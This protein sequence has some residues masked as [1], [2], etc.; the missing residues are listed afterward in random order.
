M[1]ELVWAA[2]ASHA[3]GQLRVQTAAGQDQERID[4]VYAGWAQLR[5]S[6]EA[7]GPDV[8]IVVGT[9]HFQTFSYDLMPVFAIGR[10][11]A[12]WTWGEFGTGVTQVPGLPRLA[13]AIHADLVHDGFDLASSAEMRIDHAYSCPLAF[14]APEDS[15]PTVPLFVNS[16]VPP[17]PPLA[18]CRALG[19][20]LRAAIER[21]QIA[22]RVAIVG[23]GGIS[24]WIGVPQTGR[25]NPQF[26]RRFLSDFEA[27]DLSALDALD[28]QTLVRDG[29][30]GAG[31]L[32]CW[33]VTLGA[34]GSLG[35]RTL[36]YEPVQAWI[37]GISLV[38]VAL[39]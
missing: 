24:H 3:G 33:M 8:L 14:L 19:V 32:R 17:L 27:P 34:A 28:D 38:E 5:Q 21:Q 9:D 1:G 25:I 18:R 15:I 35:A 12:S 29:G 7:A 22:R 37:T 2:C 4:R 31:E 20:A 39:S 16:F 10:G 6:L 26:D 23:T 11:E 30:P 36:V 13:D